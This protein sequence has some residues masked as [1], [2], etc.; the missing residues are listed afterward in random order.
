MFCF[1]CMLVPLWFSI[2]RSACSARGTSAS[3]CQSLAFGT[4]ATLSSKLF[5][6]ELGLLHV[7]CIGRRLSNFLFHTLMVI[8]NISWFITTEKFRFIGQRISLIGELQTYLLIIDHISRFI[9][10]Q[11]FWYILGLTRICLRTFPNWAGLV[12]DNLRQCLSKVGWHFRFGHV[13]PPFALEQLDCH[14]T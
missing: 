5:V 7:M 1:I 9:R 6:S 13:G 4:S 11:N 8:E 2:L 12:V 3:L 14:K 10:S